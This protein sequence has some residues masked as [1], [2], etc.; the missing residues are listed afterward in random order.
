MPMMVWYDSN[1]KKMYVTN[2]F[3]STFTLVIWADKDPSIVI[4]KKKTKKVDE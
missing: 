3:F 4:V 2:S 1:Y